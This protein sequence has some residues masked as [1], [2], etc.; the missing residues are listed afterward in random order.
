[1]NPST[2]LLNIYSITIIVSPSSISLRKMEKTKSRDLE[3]LK[4]SLKLI[5]IVIFFEAWVLISLVWS[6]I[7]VRPPAEVNLYWLL[8]CHAPLLC[9]AL[10]MFFAYM[11]YLDS[12]FDK[13]GIV[14]NAGTRSTANILII[15]YLACEMLSVLGGMIAV[16]WRVILFS[17]CAGLEDIHTCKLQ[18]HQT[19]ALALLILASAAIV[20]S[21]IGGITALLIL[22]KFRDM[23]VS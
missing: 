10:F 17:R 1:M 21:S 19:V 9:S 16:L 6:P 15:V 7:L 5:M 18:I 11:F 13:G 20:L 8:I 12:A 14:T 22:M 3:S 2:F 23:R 4:R